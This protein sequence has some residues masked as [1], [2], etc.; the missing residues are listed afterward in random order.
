MSVDLYHWSGGAYFT[1]A[2]PAF[3]LAARGELGNPKGEPAKTAASVCQCVSGS[4]QAYLTAIPP[5][6]RSTCAASRLQLGWL[7][8]CASPHLENVC[9]RKSPRK[10]G[11]SKLSFCEVYR[12]SK[13][14]L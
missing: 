1:A 5:L 13:Q 4:K 6:A 7:A 3:L 2:R 14:A 10:E 11:G 8:G 9:L 12:A